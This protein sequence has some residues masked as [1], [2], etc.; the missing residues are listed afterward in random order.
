MN[1]TYEN[2]V[3][4]PRIH[5]RHPELTDDDVRAA[6]HAKLLVGPR[7]PNGDWASIGLDGNGRL[8]EMVATIDGNGNFLIF[9]AMIPPSERTLKEVRAY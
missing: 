8:L 3:V 6:W 7:R 5:Q 9:H 4:D 2:P 1:E